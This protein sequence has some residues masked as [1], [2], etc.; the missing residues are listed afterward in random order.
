MGA[1]QESL[2]NEHN[3]LGAIN[4]I[5]LITTENG[6]WE[7]NKTTK[8]EPIC[9]LLENRNYDRTEIMANLK[10][11]LTDSPSSIAALQELKAVMDNLPYLTQ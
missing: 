5:E 2:A 4:E 9:E 7:I 3:L 10:N 11:Q 8:G 1:Y 6:N